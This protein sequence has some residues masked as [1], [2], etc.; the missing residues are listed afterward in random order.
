MT[1]IAA[2]LV[3]AERQLHELREE[4]AALRALLST[5]AGIALCGAFDGE[6]E[7]KFADSC[8]G[9]DAIRQLPGAVSRGDPS[10]PFGQV[11]EA[12]VGKVRF[13]ACW[14]LPPCTPQTHRHIS[15][16]VAT[17]KR[18]VDVRSGRCRC[19]DALLAPAFD[20]AKVGL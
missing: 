13:V 10:D 8:V 9:F 16:H 20:P 7:I 14:P 3:T 4:T 6:C 5:P 2:E 1:S 12:K 18:E 11:V 17:Y 19:C 15:Q